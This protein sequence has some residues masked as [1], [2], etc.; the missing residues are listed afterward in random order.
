[1]FVCLFVCLFFVV[2]GDARAAF[3]ADIDCV[4]CVY[5]SC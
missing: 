2:A 4:G 5:L 3:A 1:M